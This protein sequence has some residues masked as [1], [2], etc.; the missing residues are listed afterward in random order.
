MFCFRL[1]DHNESDEP[2]FTQPVMYKAIRSPPT[3]EVYVDRLG[4]EGLLTADAVEGM[5]AKW[6]AHLDAEFEASQSY[7]PDKADWLDGRWEGLQSPR[8]FGAA[9]DTAAT[10]AC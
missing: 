3:L 1:H 5:K 7:R 10:R 8:L 9:G 2:A 4:A 6:I